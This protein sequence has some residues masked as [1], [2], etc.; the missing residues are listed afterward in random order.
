[1]RFFIGFL[2][3]LFC[4]Y[5][6]AVSA[7]KTFTIVIDPGHGGKDTGAI[8]QNGVREKNVV[9]AISKKIAANL[10]QIPGVRVI[11]TRKTDVYLPL[12]TRINLARQ[13]NADIFVAVHADAYFNQQAKGASV[14]ALSQ[15]GATS[16][17]ARWLVQQEKYPELGGIDLGSLPDKS[18]MLRS[19]L[20]D[21]AQTATIRDS[22]SLGNRVL[23]ALDAISALHYRHVTQAPFVV[24][25][26]PDIPSVL[27]E[28]G[29]LSN[30]FEAARLNNAAYQDRIAAAVSRGIQ[31]YIQTSYRHTTHVLSFS[32]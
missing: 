4:C 7:Q 29:F 2:V 6:A 15:H 24:L 22:V 13:H 26:S 27:I 5:S 19:V 31:A 14:Y 25:K 10:S 11:L 8:G 20:I 32:H 3:A 18:R 1:M 12:R 17:A 21:M 28:T 30:A 16:E 9:L 23:A